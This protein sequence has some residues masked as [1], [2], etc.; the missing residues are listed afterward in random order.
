MSIQD[1][2]I[3]G[4]NIGIHNHYQL[5][6]SELEKQRPDVMLSV[7]KFSGYEAIS[8]PWNIPLR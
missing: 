4:D 8:Q 2:A 3:A 5:K 1:Y 7:L 6:V